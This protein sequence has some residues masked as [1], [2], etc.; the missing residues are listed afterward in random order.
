MSRSLRAITPVTIISRG[1]LVG[2]LLYSPLLLA[3]EGG[4]TL[5]NTVQ[6]QRGKITTLRLKS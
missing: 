3:Q 5:F 6:P 2:G 4:I 1:L